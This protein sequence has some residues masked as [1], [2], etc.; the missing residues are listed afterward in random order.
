MSLSSLIVQ[1]GIATIRQVE[2]AL[3]RQVLYGGDLVTNLLEVAK[4]DEAPLTLL[5]AESFGLAAATLGQLPSADERARGFVTAEMASSR[6]MV[7][8]GVENG[9]LV[10]AIAEP[11]PK[12]VEEELSFA[13]GLRLVQ[14]VAP[15]VR[16]RE[17]LAKVYGAP[18]ERRLQRLL[19]RLGAAPLSEAAIPSTE[20]APVSPVRRPSTRPN[21]IPLATSAASN[22]RAGQKTTLGLAP[23]PAI[24]VP[25]PTPATRAPALPP[26]SL[27]HGSGPAPRPQRRRRGPIVTDQ[28]VVELAEATTRDAI[29]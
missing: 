9:A 19:T 27:V 10:V 12:E 1:R 22:A 28:A 2:E 23:P 15:M 21:P 16:V 17:A 25:G 4:L 29:L 7:P 26:P 18:L 14:R 6:A 8:I 5:L 24:I 13:L 20:R 11:L 3:A